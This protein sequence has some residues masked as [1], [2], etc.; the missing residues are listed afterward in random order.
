MIDVPYTII[1]RPLQAKHK[2]SYIWKYFI[3]MSYSTSFLIFD[4]LQDRIEY[5]IENTE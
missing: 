4:S 1:S 3:Q 2:N 5:R